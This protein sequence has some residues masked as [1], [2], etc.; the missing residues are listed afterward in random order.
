MQIVVAPPPIVVP[1]EHNIKRWQH[2]QIRIFP[3]LSTWD[4]CMFPFLNYLTNSLSKFLLNLLRNFQIITAHFIKKT[5]LYAI[6]NLLTAI[7]VFS[8]MI[9]A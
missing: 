8:G 7:E 3:K 1:V 9:K 5:L 6:T 2:D 4:L